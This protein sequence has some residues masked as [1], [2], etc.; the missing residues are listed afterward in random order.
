MKSQLINI[1]QTAL[2]IKTQIWYAPKSS[3]R[4]GIISISGDLNSVINKEK[5]KRIIDCIFYHVGNLTY[6]NFYIV[7]IQN[8]INQST[9]FHELFEQ[10][11]YDGYKPIFLIHES[12]KSE[13]VKGMLCETNLTD[14]I[15]FISQNEKKKRDDGGKKLPIYR[16]DEIKINTINQDKLRHR[17][18][19]FEINGP[20]LNAMLIEL[21]GELRPGSGDDPDVEYI[22]Q[23][24]TDTISIEFP[25]PLIVD[26][27]KLIYTWGDKLRLIP[28]EAEKDP[29]Y[30]YRLVLR[31]EQLESYAYVIGDEKRICSTV[32]QAIEELKTQIGKQ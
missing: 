3:L 5:E 25:K 20:F 27:T 17:T 13:L 4:V 7:D 2:N 8:T 14:A 10:V 32:E 28:F 29:N 24:I 18:E 12:Q 23:I 19:V 15:N 30:P 9:F 6:S 26:A 11:Y 1:Y 21:E 16:D 31:S 22:V